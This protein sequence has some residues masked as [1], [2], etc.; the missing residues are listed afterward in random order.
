MTDVPLRCRCGHVVGVA[1]ELSPSAGFRF[2]CYCDDCRGFVRFLDRIDVLDAAG[3]TDI[4]HLAPARVQLTAGL[5]SLRCVQFSAKVLRWYAD[6]CRT[7]IANTAVRPSFPVV[8][9]IH[10][11]MDHA[12][13]GRSRDAVLGRPVCGIFARS[14]TGPLPPDA[15]PPPSLGMFMRR[16]AKL[17]RW[18]LGG[19]HRPNPF[20]ERDGAPRARPE[21]MRPC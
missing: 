17:I 12:A 20:F 13:T 10:A 7:P 21:S 3:G 6:C 2:I 8:A 5:E 1:R 14:A 16:G 11:I 19:L 18:R 9:L 4:F 15:P